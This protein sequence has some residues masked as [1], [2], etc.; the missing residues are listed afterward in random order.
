[1]LLYDVHAGFIPMKGHKNHTRCMG[2][3]NVEGRKIST[4]L[5]PHVEKTACLAVYEVVERTAVRKKW[6]LKLRIIFHSG[7]AYIFL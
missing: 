1:M 4:S 2:L 5:Y 6:S 7:R 3:N